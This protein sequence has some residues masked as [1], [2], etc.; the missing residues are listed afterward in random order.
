MAIKDERLYKKLVPTSLTFPLIQSGQGLSTSTIILARIVIIL[1]IALI[2]SLA[3]AG[4]Y[5]VGAFILIVALVF[6]LEYF[7]H[8]FFNVDFILSIIISIYCILIQLWFS[9]LIVLLIFITSFA[10]YRIRVNNIKKQ[11]YI[12]WKGS[13]QSEL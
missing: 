11:I 10:I 3:I 8:R 6:R 13:N 2:I 5:I 9:V 12:A 7:A 1:G 4:H